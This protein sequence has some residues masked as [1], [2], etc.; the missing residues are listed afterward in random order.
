MIRGLIYSECA[1]IAAGMPSPLAANIAVAMTSSICEAADVPFD[2][3]AEAGRSLVLLL[4][5]DPLL[6]HHGRSLCRG[7]SR[8]RASTVVGPAF[9]VE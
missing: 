6:G 1:A 2:P 9:S 7:Q 3:Y 4:A 8:P 5:D